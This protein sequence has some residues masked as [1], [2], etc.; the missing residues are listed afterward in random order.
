[1]LK[2][3]LSGCPACL[4]REKQSYGSYSWD[5]TNVSFQSGISLLGTIP[6]TNKNRSLHILHMKQRQKSKPL[7]TLSMHLLP[8]FIPN[9]HTLWIYKKTLCIVHR[10]SSVWRMLMVQKTSLEFINRLNFFGRQTF[11]LQFK[12]FVKKP[13]KKQP[14]R[15]TFQ[16]LFVDFYFCDIQQEICYFLLCFWTCRLLK[17]IY[18]GHLPIP[19]WLQKV[20]FCFIKLF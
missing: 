5:S 16:Y 19:V 3:R 13:Q 7:N 1:M 20:S 6:K 2:Q 15:K 11:F 14:P 12:W 18:E 8:R 9:T 17:D 4:N 10:L